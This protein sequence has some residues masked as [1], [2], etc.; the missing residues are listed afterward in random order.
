MG[1]GWCPK[2][3]VAL[4]KALLK[5]SMDVINAVQAKAPVKPA[6]SIADI[7]APGVD[8]WRRSGLRA[9]IEASGLVK[10]VEALPPT[11]H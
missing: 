7:L 10:T 6:K 2:S 3:S 9:A 4:P 8:I 11:L 1:A 5:P